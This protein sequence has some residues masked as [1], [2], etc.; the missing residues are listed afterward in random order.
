MLNNNQYTVRTNNWIKMQKNVILIK[1]KISV[2][3]III[4][5]NRFNYF[6]K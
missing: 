4:T 3:E 2:R 5:D 1:V 6:S